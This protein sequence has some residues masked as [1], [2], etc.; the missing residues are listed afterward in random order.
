MNARLRFVGSAI[1]A[2]K[3][4]LIFCGFLGLRFLAEDQSL[5]YA[6]SGWDSF[7]YLELAQN[8]YEHDH[9]SS[10][11]YPLLPLLMRWIAPLLGGSYL[12]AGVIVSNAAGVAALYL[13]HRLVYMEHGETAARF[14]LLGLLAFPTA[15]FLSL[16]YTEGLFLLELMV[17]FWAM[18]TNRVRLGAAAAF[19]MPLTRAIG[20]FVVIVLLYHWYEQWRARKSSD[21]SKTQKPNAWLWAAGCG[22]LGWLTC[23]GL[24]WH[25]TGDP[26][27]T[28]RAQK[29]Y[30]YHPSVSNIF[31]VGK[32][33]AAF[34]NWGS[35]HTYTDSIV[36]RLAFLFFVSSLYGIWKLSRTYF[37]WAILAGFVPAFSN[38][39]FSYV[40]YVLCV[41]PLFILM[42]VQCA[43]PGR[44]WMFWYYFVLLIV[45]QACFMIR[46]VAHWW[47][48]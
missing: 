11:F 8:G 24:M 10:A 5:D 19:L 17:V 13:F 2:Q 33:G 6:L 21:T 15:I 4:F 32:W 22:V 31:N 43:K 26:F 44:A 48:G 41:F 14:A 29:F 47:A 1:A 28:F 30:A 36:D 25:W 45:L 9:M 37:V 20:L 38:C 23:L 27:E 46:Y 3:I 18:R 16:L 34:F 7:R 40:R 39:F 42:G 35:F 12:W